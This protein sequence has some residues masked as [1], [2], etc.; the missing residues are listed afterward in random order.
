T[1]IKL[2]E[3]QLREQYLRLVHANKM[4]SLG[5]LI[6][7]VAHEVNN[8]NNY[9]SLNAPLLAEAWSDV[10]P[11]LDRHYDL[12]GE[13]EIAGLPYRAEM[14]ETVPQLIG[15][16]EKGSLRIQRL[17]AD[18]KNFSRN[19]KSAH[20]DIDIDQVMKTAIDLIKSQIK[21][22]TNHFKYRQPKH[23]PRIRG[24][25][26]RLEQVFINILQ[27]SCQALASPEERIEV[28]LEHA[29][30]RS[31]V[32]VRV[33]DGGCG[34]PPE[35][36]SKVSEPFFTTKHEQGGTGLGLSIAAKIIQEHG[37]KIEFR[38]VPAGGTEVVV[39]LPVP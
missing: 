11:I 36:L 16:I 18:L 6:S 31:Q 19:D 23:L 25:F 14:R 2:A 39:G 38:R 33:I 27:N 17:V 22:S 10:R 24:D 13:F 7:G 30:S 3:D 1:D 8:P 12:H 9:I 15:G 4:A 35:I 32:V 26:Q 29:E 37:G 20:R 28:A 5:A 21:Q 34:I